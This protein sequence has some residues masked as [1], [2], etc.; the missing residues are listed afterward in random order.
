MLSLA[1]G[2]C[3]HTFPAGEGLLYH[4][5]TGELYALSAL[6]SAMIGL[7]AEKSFDR[8]LDF[9]DLLATLRARGFL[10]EVP[11]IEASLEELLHL[12]VVVSAEP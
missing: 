1:D 4:P 12:G 6:P 10:A 3:T 9:D 11:E 2:W 8:T 5:F 7:I